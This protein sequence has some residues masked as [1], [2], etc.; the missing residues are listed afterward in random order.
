MAPLRQSKKEQGELMRKLR[1]VGAPDTDVKEAVPELKARKKVLEN[2]ELAPAPQVST[3]DS[4]KI[5]DLLKRRFFYNQSFA[6]HGG[7]TG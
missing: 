5:E 2:K 7:I 1:T 6:I 4:A 3:F